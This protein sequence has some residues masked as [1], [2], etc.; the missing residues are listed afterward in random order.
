MAD[1]AGGPAPV[2]EPSVAF[3]RWCP[4]G[5]GENLEGI[6]AVGVYA[7]PCFDGV[8]PSAVNMFNRYKELRLLWEYNMRWGRRPLCN[9]K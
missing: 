4:W 2:V 6:E 7:L 3:S 9:S 8:L 1:G 5:K